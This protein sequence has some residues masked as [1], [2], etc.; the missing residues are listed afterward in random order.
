MRQKS[1]RTQKSR[2]QK[3]RRRQKSKSI[4]SIVICHWDTGYLVIKTD[5]SMKYRIC[6]GLQLLVSSQISTPLGYGGA[7]HSARS[8]FFNIQ[9]PSNLTFWSS[10]L[11]LSLVYFDFWLAL[12][13][14]FLSGQN[15]HHH[16]QSRFP[17]HCGFEGQCYINLK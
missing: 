15:L 2:R 6:S 4:F 8:F 3:S 16:F 14:R 7:L 5:T 9:L 13:K 10:F 1:R 12:Q 17:L 11:I